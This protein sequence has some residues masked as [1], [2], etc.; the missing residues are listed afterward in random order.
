MGKSNLTNSM[1]L[2]RGT[3]TGYRV[4]CGLTVTPG[5]GLISIGEVPKFLEVPIIFEVP[6]IL[7]LNILSLKYLTVS[8]ANI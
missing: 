1:A 3:L 5:G 8:C 2:N 6:N 4:G 7:S